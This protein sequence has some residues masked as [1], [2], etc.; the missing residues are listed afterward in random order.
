MTQDGVQLFNSGDYHIRTHSKRKFSRGRRFQEH[1]EIVKWR[2]CEPGPLEYKPLTQLHDRVKNQACVTIHK[3]EIIDESKYEIVGGSC[4]V[5]RP[6][7]LDKMQRTALDVA[8][9]SFVS[10]R[11][12][13]TQYPYEN[14]HPEKTSETMLHQSLVN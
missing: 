10:N 13:F 2:G 9:R 6:D 12:K 1:Y 5:M 14:P 8:A 7:L 4:K 11:N 3:P